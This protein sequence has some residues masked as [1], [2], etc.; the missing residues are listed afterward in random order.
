MH[1]VIELR[2][3]A[4]SKLFV[5]VLLGGI[6][7]ALLTGTV[8][9]GLWADGWMNFISRLGLGVVCGTYAYSFCARWAIRADSSRIVAHHGFR[10][11]TVVPR[12]KAVRLVV[13]LNGTTIQGANNE[14]L[15]TFAGAPWRIEDVDRF[16][17]HAGLGLMVN[18]YK[19]SNRRDLD[20]PAHA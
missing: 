12:A 5:G 16:A 6:G 9:S 18:S 8:A 14:P 3:S 19:R 15:L 1:H 10:K 17:E 7:V 13:M 4:T 20:P 11:V 2:P